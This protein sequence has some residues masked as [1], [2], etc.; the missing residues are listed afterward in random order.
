[1]SQPTQQDVDEALREVDTLIDRIDDQIVDTVSGQTDD[2]QT[3]NGRV[4]QHGTHVYQVLG[5][6][7]FR[8][9]KVRAEFNVAEALAV[10][11]A[12]IQ[13]DGGTATQVEVSP[14]D[15][16]QAR[17]ELLNGLDDDQ[18]EEIRQGVIDRVTDASVEAQLQTADDGRTVFGIELARQLHIYSEDVS[19]AEF[20]D[21]VQTIVNQMWRTKEFLLK[22]YGV[23]DAIGG[24]T[25]TGGPRGIQ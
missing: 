15:V 14:Q 10:Q 5:S 9:L 24:G 3:V 13:A 22:E 6:T 17:T 7:A 23:R 19:P 2:G 21:E 18:T 12:S 25:P 16:Q 20:A 8:H 1:M 4:V 11:R